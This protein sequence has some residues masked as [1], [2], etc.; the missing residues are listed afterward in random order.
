[1]GWLTGGA[2][3]DYKP[4][5][6]ITPGIGQKYIDSLYDFDPNMF[7]GL[8]AGRFLKGAKQDYK[9]LRSGK[10]I[11]Q[12]GGFGATLGAIKSS[13]GAADRDRNR[14]FNSNIALANQPGLAAAQAAEMQRKSGQDQSNTIAGAASDLYNNTQQFGQNAFENLQARRQNA[15]GMKLNAL[16]Q[17]TNSYL[18]AYRPPTGY[19]GGLLGGLASGAGALLGGIGG[20]LGSALGSKL[21]SALFNSGTP[22]FG[23]AKTVRGT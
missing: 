16:G 5:G 12:I 19:S 4:I 2:K 20:P 14:E 21:G 6:G 3:F 9:D 17:A 15:A 8:G 22:N 23:G 11:S 10:D 18:G 1:M 13:Y 7:G